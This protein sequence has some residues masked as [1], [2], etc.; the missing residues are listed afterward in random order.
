MSK[1]DTSHVSR[2]DTA[3][4]QQVQQLRARVMHLRLLNYG[5]HSRP[6]T[7]QSD[8]YGERQVSHNARR[9]PLLRV[10]SERRLGG[11][12]ALVL[13]AACSVIGRLRALHD[14]LGEP[15]RVVHSD[16]SPPGGGD[17]R[18][19]A[20]SRFGAVSCPGLRAGVSSVRQ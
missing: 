1:A 11:G 16:A 19:P 5:R 8:G 18:A 13:L 3:I 12:F 7:N 6:H 2:Q 15:H 20:V 17:G 4:E 10:A 14:V 9:Q